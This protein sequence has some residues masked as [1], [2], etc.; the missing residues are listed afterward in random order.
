MSHNV[1]LGME[2]ERRRTMHMQLK[3]NKKCKRMKSMSSS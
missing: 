3:L 2:M 1:L